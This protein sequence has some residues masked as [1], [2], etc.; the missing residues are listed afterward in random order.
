[1]A[2]TEELQHAIAMSEYVIGQ[3][4]TA[5]AAMEA[6]VA[7]GTIEHVSESSM[8]EANQ[9]VQDILDLL[10]RAQRALYENKGTLEAQAAE[11]AANPEQV[12][13]NPY[14]DANAN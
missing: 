3:L 8:A 2:T 11:A 12:P 7:T 1:M 14:D 13:D 9:A 6:V 10:S 4:Q 5:A